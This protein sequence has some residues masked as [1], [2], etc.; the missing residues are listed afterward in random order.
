MATKEPGAESDLA[1][2]SDILGAGRKQVEVRAGGAFHLVAVAYLLRGPSPAV[3]V[4]IF[5]STPIVPVDQPVVRSRNR[6]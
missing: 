2:R 1:F 6:M 5:P 3:V 4:E